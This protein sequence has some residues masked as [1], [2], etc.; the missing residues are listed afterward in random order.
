MIDYDG[1]LLLI[2]HDRYFLD[3]LVSR[4]FELSDGG[5]RVFEGNYSDYLRKRN[6]EPLAAPEVVADLSKNSSQTSRK[7]QKRQEAKAR[8]EISK[9]RKKFSAKVQHFEMLIEKLEAER[10]RIENLMAD[11]E[12]YK[13]KMEAAKYGKRYQELQNEIPDAMEEWESA[14]LKLEQLLNSL[15]T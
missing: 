4:V 15:N 1:T 11:P 7:E 3:K 2:S 8:Q 5:L 14:Q 13:D 12:F 10:L 9:Q 6:T